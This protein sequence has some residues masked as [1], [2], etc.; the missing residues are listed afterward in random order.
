MTFWPLTVG[1]TE[2]HTLEECP[3]LHDQFWM[4]QILC[5]F[6]SILSACSH[7]AHSSRQGHDWVLQLLLLYSWVLLCKEVSNSNLLHLDL[8]IRFIIVNA[9]SR[10]QKPFKTLD[11]LCIRNGSKTRNLLHNILLVQD[12][13]PSSCEDVRNPDYSPLSWESRNLI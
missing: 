8:V 1:C 2:K 3:A 6:L 4:W 9:C 13:V 10:T 7:T 11:K 12:D 5:P